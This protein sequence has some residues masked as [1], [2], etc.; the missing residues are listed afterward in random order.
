MQAF[1]YRPMAFAATMAAVAAVL[2]S[3]MIGTWR[4]V[5]FLVLVAALAALL[6][7]V[8]LF[9]KRQKR[10]LEALLCLFAVSVTV[11]SSLYFF[12]VR[13]ARFC[14]LEGKEV[15][16][17]GTVLER[18][19]SVAYAGS[20]RVSLDRI[21]GASCSVDAVIECEFASSMQVGDRFRLRGVARKFNKS[22]LY[23]EEMLRLSEDS[24]LLLSCADSTDC[25]IGERDMTNPRVLASLLNLRLSYGLRNRIGGEAGGVAS[26]LLL[27]NRSFLSADT[28]LSFRRAGISHLLALSGL[29]VSILIAFV[30]FLTRA[31]R[32]RQ[33]ARFYLIPLFAFLYL[34]ITGFALSTLR[35]V[36]MVV[37]LYLSILLGEAYDSLTALTTSL[38]LTLILMPHSVLSLSL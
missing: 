31:F 14:A 25:E 19:R 18:G 24:V 23:D 28:V 10:L 15:E 17:E 33:R 11:G 36:L 1:R 21:D 38:M 12:N 32:I 3:R 20:F 16:V 7:A 8:F 35:A 27:G 30:D 6:I 37:V 5:F 2:S 13:Y 9:G 29:H 26:A 22:D 34:V 4:T